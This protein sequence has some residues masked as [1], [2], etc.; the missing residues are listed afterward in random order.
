M[1]N[2]KSLNSYASCRMLP[3]EFKV[4]LEFNNSQ[5]RDY[6]DNEKGKF[7]NK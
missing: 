1:D 4:K 5:C 2:G 6:I 7:Q 3:E